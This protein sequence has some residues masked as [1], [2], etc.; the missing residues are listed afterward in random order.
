LDMSADNMRFKQLAPLSKINLA[1]VTT[2]I[3]F[4]LVLYGS[5]FLY[6]PRFNGFWFNVGK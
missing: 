3:E 6:T 4:I 1:I 5:L 2:A